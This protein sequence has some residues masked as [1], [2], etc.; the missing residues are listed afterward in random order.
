MRPIP[1]GEA[2]ELEEFSENEAVACGRTPRVI[3]VYMQ[4]R[5]TCPRAAMFAE[6]VPDLWVKRRSSPLKRANAKRPLRFLNRNAVIGVQSISKD[7]AAQR[8]CSVLLEPWQ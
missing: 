6:G 5:R 8:Q 1:D 4:Q 3:N 2:L 7:L